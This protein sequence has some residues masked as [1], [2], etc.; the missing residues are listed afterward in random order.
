MG[1]KHTFR[2]N[3]PPRPVVVNHLDVSEVGITVKD[4]VRPGRCLAV[5]EGQGYDALEKSR[6][7]K[8]LDG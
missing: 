1:D 3:G 4:A 8:W 6:V 5:V 7:F 2:N